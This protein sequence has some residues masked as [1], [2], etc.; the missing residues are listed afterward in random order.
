MSILRCKGNSLLHLLLLFSLSSALLSA[1]SLDII[2]QPQ[3]IH[4]QHGSFIL[5]NQTHYY[6]DTPLA[7]TAITYLNAHLK[8]SSGYSLKSSP[9]KAELIF[10]YTHQKDI[11]SEGY[12]LDITTKHIT[13]TARDREGFFYGIITLLQLTK[14]AI[15]QQ[16][17]S[18]DKWPIPACRI[19]DTPR[20]QWRGMMLDVSRNFFSVDYVKKFIDR[21]AQYKLNRFHWHLTDDEGWRMEIKH[22]PLLTKVGA[23]RGPGTKLPFSTFP[24][25]R[26]PKKHMQSGYYSQQ[27][28][29]E[30]VAYAK[31]RCIEILPEIDLPAHAKAAVTAYPDILLDP[32]DTSRFR[33]VQKVANNTINPA[34]ESTYTML[35]GIIG[36]VAALFPFGYI[37]LGG[38]EVPK[39]AWHG[40]PAVKRLME[41]KRLRNTK[42]VEDY[43]F[44]RMDKITAK[45]GKYIAGWQEITE[46]HPHIRELSLVMAWKS[47]QAGQKAIK[48]GYPTIMTPVQYLYFDQQY[49]RSKKE[50]GHTWSTPV[51]LHKVYSFDP[52]ASATGIQACLWSETLQNE[53]IA[54]YLTW[55]RALALSEVAWS[56][57][58]NWESF[59][60]RVKE[61]ALPR[62][63]VQKVDYR[64]Q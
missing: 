29:R 39:G 24:T 60:M 47:T 17:S 62:L 21:M 58:K 25:M 54:D 13:I 35:E 49:V 32:H 46:K 30:I 2:P 53:H 44:A 36:E 1:N 55:P 26:G 12:H 34:L 43:F 56:R 37:H 61:F 10:H 6:S 27:Q 48:K 28:I 33:S 3:K 45:Y 8:Q 31:A 51:S 52:P 23:K 19:E 42:A 4:K 63:K 38:D 59:K 11:K 18:K 5:T 7:D 41:Q 64:K 15:W 9:S 50:P 22:Y 16:Q 20:Y 14:P 40:S 57:K